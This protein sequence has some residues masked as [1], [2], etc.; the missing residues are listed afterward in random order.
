MVEP[1]AVADGIPAG[2]VG[3][4]DGTAEAAGILAQAPVAEA[5][6]GVGAVRVQAVDG[7]QARLGVADHVR[8]AAGTLEAVAAA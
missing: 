5:R 3:T 7:I 2:V 8:V 4:A 1:G 6:I